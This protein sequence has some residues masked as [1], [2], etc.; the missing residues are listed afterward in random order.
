MMRGHCR[1]SFRKLSGKF[2]SVKI[3]GNFPSLATI[4]I[5][6]D[7]LN[8]QKMEVVKEFGFKRTAAVPYTLLYVFLL[9]NLSFL[10]MHVAS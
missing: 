6:R 8:V 5:Y 2:P 4:G 1:E 3:S 10:L 9:A 7:V